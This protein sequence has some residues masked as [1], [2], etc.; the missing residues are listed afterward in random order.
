MGT[1]SKYLTDHKA[2][3]GARHFGTYSLKATHRNDS[4]Q[5]VKVSVARRELLHCSKKA[6]RDQHH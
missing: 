6:R 4:E 2:V 5:C 3:S 1:V